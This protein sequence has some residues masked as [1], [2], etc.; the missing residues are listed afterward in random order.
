MSIM[1]TAS[2]TIAH[3][4]AAAFNTRD[5]EQ[6]IDVFTPDVTYHDLFYGTFSGHTGLRELFGRMYAEGINHQW[7]MRA[8]A[9]SECRTIGEW[10]FEFTVSDQVPHGAGRTLRFG[11]V[12]V[13]ETREGRCHSYR[14]YF[15]R[16]A[17][18]FAVGITPDSVSRIVRR[19]SSVQATLPKSDTLSR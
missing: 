6:V 1:T 10:H 15:D 18:L 11:G 13:F 3:R 16:T 8:V 12:S 2:P 7:T 9:V 14:E 4:F 5:V 17:A 19:R